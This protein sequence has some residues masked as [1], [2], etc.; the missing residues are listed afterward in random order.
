MRKLLLALAILVL[1]GSLY[2]IEFDVLGNAMY[3]GDITT[4]GSEG[5]DSGGVAL[6]GQARIKLSI[7]RADA[8]IYLHD[9]GDY[10]LTLAPLDL[11]LSLDLF[12]LRI[13]AG[14]GPVFIVE[15]GESG[16]ALNNLKL[17]AD[18][19]LGRHFELGLEGYLVSE[20]MNAFSSAEYLTDPSNWLFG[21]TLGLRL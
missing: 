15:D 14:F 18:L 10:S 3:L 1:S 12:F 7:L 8:G 11:G 9:G 2:A 5:L 16:P 17:S 6:G 19:L 4:L 13:G 20:S 21:T